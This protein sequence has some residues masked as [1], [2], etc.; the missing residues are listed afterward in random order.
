MNRDSYAIALK[1]ALTEIQNAYPDLTH[2]FIFTQ[3]EN[4]ISGEQ[5]TDENTMN[6][7][8]DAFANLKEKAETIGEINSLQITGK[9]GNL[10]L[11]KINDMYLV[12]STTKNMDNTHIYAI[13]HVIIPTILKTMETIESPHLPVTPSTQKKL[14][15]DTLTGFFA[16]DAVQIDTE[17]LD[18]WTQ[19]NDPRARVKAAITGNAHIPDEISQVHIETFS[20]NTTVCKVKEVDDQNVKGKNM[21][22]I[23]EKLAK[24]LE[25]TKGDMVMVK[26]ID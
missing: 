14:V 16:G 2:S 1:T 5:E 15:V 12:L 4:I 11:S 26:P 24:S 7:I 9:K 13:T 10:T 8:L 6:T 25:I 3:N 21:I 22:R 17:I 20:G 18:E 23:P 19:N